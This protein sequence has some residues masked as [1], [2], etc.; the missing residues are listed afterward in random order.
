MSRKIA[1]TGIFTGVAVVLLYIGV[2]MPTGKLTLYFLASMAVSVAIIE[3]GAG[4]G[5]LVYF[6]AC[7]L[8]SLV[9]GNILGIVPFAFFF[10]HYPIFKFFIE[11]GRKVAVEVLLKLAVFNISWFSWY[12][13]FKSIFIEVLPVQLTKNIGLLSVFIAAMQVVFFIYDYV[14]SRLL[15]YYESKLSIIKRS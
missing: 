5:V 8:A 7:I 11:K 1:F 13:L 2:V 6:A 12:L 3:F 9:A 10:G 4:A 14:Y 15:F